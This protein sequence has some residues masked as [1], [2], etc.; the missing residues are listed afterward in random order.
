VHHADILR[1][2][3]PLGR[4]SVVANVPYA[5]T[6]ALVRRL[7]DA[8]APPAEALLIVQREA[9][10]KFAGEPTETLFSVLHKPRFTFEIVGA[11]RRGDFDPPPR[12]AS[13]ML[14]VT[15]RRR[16]LLDAVERGRY[17]AFVRST[18]GVGGDTVARALRG[19]FTRTQ[20]RRLARDLGFTT[21]ARPTQLSFGQWLELWRFSERASR[22][23]DPTLSRCAGCVSLA[24]EVSRRWSDELRG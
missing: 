21:G 15:P 20:V 3:L 11:L 10:E 1:F 24:E 14:R 4:Y 18:F 12:V 13:V 23:R 16:P 19:Q 5:I 8:P 22:G 2:P 6:A 9:A 7:L 17:A